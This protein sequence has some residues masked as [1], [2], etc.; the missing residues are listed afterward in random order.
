MQ[1]KF[2]IDDIVKELDAE[3]ELDTEE[4]SEEDSLEAQDEQTVEEDTEDTEALEEDAEEVEEDEEVD[5]EDAEEEDEELHR[6]NEAFKRL[7]EE[8]DQYAET[9]QFLEELAAEYGMT[10]QQLI[11]RWKDET[12]QRRAKKEGVSPEAFKRQQELERKVQ[13][14][15]IEKKKEIFN[16]RTQAIVD[17]YNLSESQ[18]DEMFAQ[19]SEMGIEITQNPELLEFVFKAMNYDTAIEQGRQKQLE[20]SKKR[21]KTSAGRTGTKGAQVNADDGWE[22]EIDS[23]LREQNLIK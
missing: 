19:A 1:E 8:R 20:I 17:R 6:R 4:V 22:K 7:R 11:D 21:S 14:L 10:K 9:D 12:A 13:E 5:E 3:F 18:V 16:I 15:E 23:I 2:N